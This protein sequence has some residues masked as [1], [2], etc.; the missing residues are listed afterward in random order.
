[1]CTHLQIF[2]TEY[3]IV[4]CGSGACAIYDIHAQPVPLSRWIMMTSP[5]GNIFR[6]TGHLCGEFTGPR[7]I[8]TQRPVT[9]SFDVFFDLRLNKRLSKQWWCW[10]FETLS[11]PLWRHRN[12]KYFVL[13]HWRPWIW[14]WTKSIANKLRGQFSRVRVTIVR[15]RDALCNQLWRH[16]QNVNKKNEILVRCVKIVILLLFM[17]SLCR[18]RNKIMY[19]LSLRT[20][21]AHTLELFVCLFPSS[22]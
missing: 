19:T 7:W 17:G 18:R 6:V 4:A 16:Q 9:R 1:M 13:L 8:P 2:V 10:W 5:N 21:Y 11:W 14:P 3:C 20:V 15:S 12:V 22:E